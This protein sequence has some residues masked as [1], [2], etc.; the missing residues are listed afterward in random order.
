MSRSLNFPILL[1]HT[2]SRVCDTK[3]AVGVGGE[4]DP[5]ARGFI[6]VCYPL[7]CEI[8]CA[9]ILR[10]MQFPYIQTWKAVEQCEHVCGS[11]LCASLVDNGNSRVKCSKRCRIRSIR[12]A[13]V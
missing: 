4:L 8:F 6:P 11:A 7:V 10:A 13:M 1:H 9:C 2:G 5:V 3:R 12:T